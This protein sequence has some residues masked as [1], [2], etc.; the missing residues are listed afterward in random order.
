[1]ST[2][3]SMEGPSYRRD[4]AS[5]RGPARNRGGAWW[6]TGW[7]VAVL[8]LMLATAACKKDREQLSAAGERGRLRVIAENLEEAYARAP[9]PQLNEPAS[10][11]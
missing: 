11:L 10:L 5:A 6:V 1:M 7:R 2:A 3:K 4:A 8:T 9:L